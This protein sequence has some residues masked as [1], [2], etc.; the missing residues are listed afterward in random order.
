[1]HKPRPQ[2]MARSEQRQTNSSSPPCSDSKLTEQQKATKKRVKYAR[3]IGKEPAEKDLALAGFLTRF[4]TEKRKA[5]KR[6]NYAKSKGKEPK[7]QDLIVGGFLKGNMNNNG[8][9][10]PLTLTQ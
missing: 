4:T 9:Q 5:R 1:M 7:V 10:T 2:A 3:S 6:V 8:E